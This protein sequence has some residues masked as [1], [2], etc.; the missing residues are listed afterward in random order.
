MNLTRTWP[1][2]RCSPP[3]LP[4]P[5]VVCAIVVCRREIAR[6]SHQ[7]RT[8]TTRTRAPTPI[9][10]AGD[11]G[12]YTQLRIG[13]DVDSLHERQERHRHIGGRRRDAA[14]RAVRRKLSINGDGLAHGGG[15]NGRVWRV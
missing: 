10:Y 12:L 5:I 3:T 2:T 13:A 15:L 7:Q 6:V 9:F 4:S 1:H 8:C 11:D 14:T